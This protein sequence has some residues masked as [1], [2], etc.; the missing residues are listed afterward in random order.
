MTKFLSNYKAEKNTRKKGATGAVITHHARYE[1]FR[2]L[3]L[4]RSRKSR[5][6][7]DSI[8]FLMKLGLGRRVCYGL[9]APYRSERKTWGHVHQDGPFKNGASM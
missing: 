6:I 4:S 7:S 3:P 9:A 5:S 2:Q 1:Y 8:R